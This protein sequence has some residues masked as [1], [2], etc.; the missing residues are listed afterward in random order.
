[1]LR[2]IKTDQIYLQSLPNGGIPH[3]TLGYSS[4]Q[5]FTA[6]SWSSSLT[7]FADWYVCKYIYIESRRFCVT[8]WF[9]DFVEKWIDHDNPTFV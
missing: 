4:S 5:G 3:G 9:Y 8:F 2:F 7:G 6:L 1:M